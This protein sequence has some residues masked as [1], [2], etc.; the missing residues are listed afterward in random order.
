MSPSYEL[1]YATFFAI[2]N[3]MVLKQQK[4]G[5]QEGW[6]LEDVQEGLEHFYN[7]HERYPT[8][9]EFDAFTYLPSSRTIQRRFGGLVGLRKELKLK[10]QKDF[11]KGKHSSSR[12][13]TINKRARKTEQEVYRYL[14]N[15]FGVQFVH[16]EYLLSDDQRKRTDFLVYYKKGTFSVDVFY[17]RDRHNLIG[18]LNSKLRKYNDDLMMQFPVIFLQ[19]NGELGQDVLD[20]VVNNKKNTLHKNQ[21]LMTFDTLKDFCVSK[22]AL[23]IAK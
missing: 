2:L 4:Q 19:M 14:S 15:Q 21:Y 10:G 11:T 7:E 17:A 8:A 5:R 6:S 20:D 22:K 18:C 1:A 13:H 23:K 12:A 3:L 16:R 9:Q